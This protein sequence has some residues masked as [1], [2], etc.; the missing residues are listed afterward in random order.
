MKLFNA[1]LLI[2]LDIKSI[3]PYVLYA[4]HII[5]GLITSYKQLPKPI[6]IFTTIAPEI[7]LKLI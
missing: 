4:T 1:F 3:N 2:H 5:Q 6:L 7:K